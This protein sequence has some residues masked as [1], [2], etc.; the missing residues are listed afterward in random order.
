MTSNSDTLDKLHKYFDRSSLKY[1]SDTKPKKHV[2]FVDNNVLP[3]NVKNDNDYSP[4]VYVCM[5]HDYDSVNLF[6]LNGADPDTIV[7][8]TPLIMFLLKHSKGNDVWD[9]INLLLDN[10]A[11]PT[12]SN[13]FGN[14]VLH[15]LTK[16]NAPYQIIEKCVRKSHPNFK[17]HNRI[18]K[19]DQ[20]QEPDYMDL[21]S[22]TDFIDGI[23][24]NA[25]YMD[26][27]IQTDFV[28]DEMIVI[29]QDL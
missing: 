16:R 14:T 4:F 24:I 19:F 28:D 2:T 11:S 22:Q 27:S 23:S 17:S 29:S 8:D 10:G 1:I 12:L 26:L 13:S 6:L 7:Y 20:K 18:I 5:N 3:I 15:M 25:D 9:I 21:S